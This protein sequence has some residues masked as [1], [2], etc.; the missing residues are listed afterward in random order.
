[1]PSVKSFSQLFGLK[2]NTEIDNKISII[3]CQVD[4][5]RREKGIY[6]FNITISIKI[7]GEI[8]EKISEEVLSRFLNYLSK[9][10]G[11][12][13]RI[14]H[15]SYGTPYECAMGIVIIKS[16]IENQVILESIGNCTRRY[17]LPIKKR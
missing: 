7:K 4:H 5:T 8:N 13:G 6:T 12:D 10:G 15:T 11:Q 3:K 1:M 14:M 16:I 9:T 2:V 17:D